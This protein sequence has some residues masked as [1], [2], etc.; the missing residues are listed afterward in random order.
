MMEEMLVWM[1]KV[2]QSAGCRRLVASLP[3][4]VYSQL[5]F[6]GD[7]WRGGDLLTPMVEEEVPV[8]CSDELCILYNV[9]IQL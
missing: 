7:V 6:E 2:L 4:G 5:F 8:F 1:L 9:V 3:S